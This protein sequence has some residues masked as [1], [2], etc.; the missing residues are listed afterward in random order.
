[1][2]Y[3][4]FCMSI[5]AALEKFI[6]SETYRTDYGLCGVLE[7][8]QET[9]NTSV[10]GLLAFRE[11]ISSRTACASGENILRLQKAIDEATK[12]TPY[13]PCALGYTDLNSTP[14][15]R[16]EARIKWLRDEAHK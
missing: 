7:H 9:R 2:S 8:L 6:N 10:G 12:E 3:K 13:L 16:H 4:T 15:Q 5:A 14:R 1:M 11:Y